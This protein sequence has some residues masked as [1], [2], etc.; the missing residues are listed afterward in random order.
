M[1][2]HEATPI[3]ADRVETLD[4]QLETIH[5]RICERAYQRFLSRGGLHGYD[6]DD[7]ARAE[8]ELRIAP[9]MSIR[10]QDHEILA[11]ARFPAGRWE[12]L[13]LLVTANQALLTTTCEEHGQVFVLLQFPREIELDSID[14]E[15]DGSVF[16]L[17]ADL[18]GHSKDGSLAREHVA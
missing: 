5:K 11:E 17:I 15:L 8:S 10:E 6:L 18:T 16:R 14:A 12:S 4:D 9:D 13:G 2:L 1:E 3:F 7:W